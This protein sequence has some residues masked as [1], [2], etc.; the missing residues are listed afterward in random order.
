MPRAFKLWLAIVASILAT[1][2]AIGYFNRP[3]AIGL[4]WSFAHGETAIAY[5]MAIGLSLKNALL[6]A[7]ACSTIDII[8]WFWLADIST[9]L[10]K[11]FWDFSPREKAC[12]DS[13]FYRWATKIPYAALPVFGLTP[14][15]IWTGIAFSK[16]FRLNKSA[17]FILVVTGNAGKMVFWG[18][19]FSLASFIYQLIMQ[20]LS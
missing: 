10:F 11:K 1:I 4:M 7:I 19:G 13:R 20:N 16:F 12:A 17:S 2:A 14:G 15:L 3:Y 18:L 9:P 8:G 6:I 5:W